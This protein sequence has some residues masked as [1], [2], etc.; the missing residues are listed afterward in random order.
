MDTRTIFIAALCLIVLAFSGCRGDKSERLVAPLPALRVHYSED[1]AGGSIPEIAEDSQIRALTRRPKVWLHLI[2]NLDSDTLTDCTFL[3]N[4]VPLG[5]VCLDV[6]LECVRPEYS[7]L[8]FEKFAD[9]GL[10]ANV[11]E[12]YY[13][14]PDVLRQQSGE[15]RM[16]SVRAAWERGYKENDGQVFTSLER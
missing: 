3:G 8:I 15:R 10:W 14:P 5:Y 13:V 16:R 4:R 1:G 7:E 12:G 6:L 11:R 9:D 2:A